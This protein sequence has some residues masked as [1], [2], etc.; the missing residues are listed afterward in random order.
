MSQYIIS[1][2]K[3]EFLIL[4]RKLN[5]LLSIIANNVSSESDLIKKRIFCEAYLEG[6]D[7]LKELKE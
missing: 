6:I 7:K 5:K 1:D 3:R 4:Q 2:N